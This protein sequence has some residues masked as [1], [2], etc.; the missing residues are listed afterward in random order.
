MSGWAW[1]GGWGEWCWWRAWG[2]WWGEWCW[3]RAWGCWWG[4]WWWWRA[5]G[6]WWGGWW[7]LGAGGGGG[8]W[9]W[10]AGGRRRGWAS[11]PRR[12]RWLVRHVRGGSQCAGRG[13]RA[14]GRCRAS[15]QG[16]GAGPRTPQAPRPG[17]RRRSGP[18]GKALP[19]ARPA[20]APA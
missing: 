4:G 14:R 3:W 1:G 6:G 5:G 12:G 19:V 8:G 15:R 7:G 16:H 18:A 20:D 13:A 10:G 11:G 17:G 9:G 2:C